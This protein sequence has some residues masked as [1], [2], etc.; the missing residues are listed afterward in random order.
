MDL[1]VLAR[2]RPEIVAPEPAPSLH[3]PGKPGDAGPRGDTQTLKERR[4]RFLAAAAIPIAISAGNAGDDG[5]IRQLALD[6][7]SRDLILGQT[8]AHHGNE[9]EIGGGEA[10]V[11]A[12]TLSRCG[13]Y[14][15]GK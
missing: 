8:V 5:S 10:N 15:R 9:I 7:D 12:D 1:E 14:D 11:T 3:A 4:R 2:A 13:V 6:A